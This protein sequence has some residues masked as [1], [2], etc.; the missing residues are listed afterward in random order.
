[1]GVGTN[2]DSVEG[3]ASILTAVEKAFMVR[4]WWTEAMMY[5]FIGPAGPAL[6]DEVKRKR[7]KR[8]VN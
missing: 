7:V 2:G 1:M 8:T 3:G 6:Q 5:F 4:S